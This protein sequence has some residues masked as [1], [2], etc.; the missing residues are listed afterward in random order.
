MQKI[1]IDTNVLVSALIQ[2]SYPYLILEQVFIS[3]KLQV[4]ISDE[5]FEEYLKV[6]NRPKFHQ[7]PD[8][9]INARMLLLHLEKYATR[10]TPN[11]KL[12]IIKDPGDN[13]L[14]ELAE[15]CNADYLI[16][17]NYKDFNMKNYKNTL[18]VT[19]KNYWEKSMMEN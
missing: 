2:H 16:T 3:P 5:L 18:I 13:K 19:P 12:N 15:T 9:E 11:I 4:C 7:Y 8:F 1:I 14:L 10:Y 6:L 17:G